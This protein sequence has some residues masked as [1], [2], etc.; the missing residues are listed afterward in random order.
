MK[1]PH[2]VLLMMR[3]PA[4]LRADYLIMALLFFSGVV[5]GHFVG[6][7]VSDSQHQELSDF[8]SV[9][10]QNAASG[11]RIPVAGVLFSY[12]RVPVALIL[13]GLSGCGLWMIPLFLVGQGFFLAFSVHT[14]VGALGRSGILFA[15]AAFGIRCL[16]VLPCCFLLAAR[17]LASANR[18]RHR[19]PVRGRESTARSA[20]YPVIVCGIVLLIGCVI[21][22]SVV[23]RLFLQI[24]KHISP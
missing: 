18:L 3:P 11:Q 10:L 14:F 5:A 7:S 19:E 13:M 23:P 9:Y 24:L 8:L 12:F 17:S 6:G 21:E 15:F 16:F 4:K 20:L 1:K 2:R 22:I